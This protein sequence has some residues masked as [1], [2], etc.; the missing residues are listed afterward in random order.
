M[1]KFR[2]VEKGKRSWSEW[3]DEKELKILKGKRIEMFQI[4][5]TMTKEQYEEYMRN[6]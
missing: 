5:E 2:Y 4:N 6:K 1:M 3:C